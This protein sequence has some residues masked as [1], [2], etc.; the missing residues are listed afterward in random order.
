[1]Q[2][3]VHV[4]VFLVYHVCWSTAHLVLGAPTVIAVLPAAVKG[5]PFERKLEPNG[6]TG[7]Q[8]R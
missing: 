3:A 5:I 4:S 7:P 2:D 1:M 8:Q 6:S